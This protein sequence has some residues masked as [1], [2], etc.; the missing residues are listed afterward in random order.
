MESI[1]KRG[2]NKGKSFV[3]N[4]NFANFEVVVDAMHADDNMVSP[5]VG[6]SLFILYVHLNSW[7]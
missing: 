5:R 6:E 2:S 4:V 7:T 1:S 3:A